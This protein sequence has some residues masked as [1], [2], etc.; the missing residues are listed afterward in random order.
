MQE[1]KSMKSNNAKVI[2]FFVGGLV[3]GALAATGIMISKNSKKAVDLTST[4]GKQF[5]VVD[6]KTWDSGVLPGDSAMDYFTLQSNIYN[7]EKN[8]AGQT[9][10]RIALANDAGK[11]VTATELPKI[12][13]LLPIAN[14]SDEE[15]KKYYDKVVNQ[16]GPGFFGNQ[17]FEKI[18]T[19]LQMQMSQQKA[20]E[21]IMRK[22]QELE[23]GGRIKILLTPPLSP[24]V[25]LDLTGYPVR[26]NKDSNIVLVEVADYLCAHCRE[27]EP[28]MEKIVKEFSSKVKFINIAY[29]LSPQGLSGSLVRGAY[30]ATKQ[31]ESLFWDY[32]SKAFQVPYAKANVPTGV[33]PTKA[34]SDV[35]IEVA[36]E[37][38]LDINAFSSCLT[39]NESNEY[40]LKVQGQFNSSTGFKGTPTFYLNGRLLEVNPQQ[41]ESTLKTALN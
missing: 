16:M 14:V 29:P 4:L 28:V 8:F 7:A 6:G 11:K 23:A 41:L 20:G 32:H 25:N 17:P 2:G 35:A 21:T 39:S 18:K 26:G 12:E 22:L 31:G 3:L 13:E 1:N 33:D 34:F 15:A 36:K 38:K 37:T 9:A 30:C 10:V 40:I 5:I 24:S 27:S 19:Q